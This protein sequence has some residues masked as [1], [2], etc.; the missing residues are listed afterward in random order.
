[1][2]TCRLRQRDHNEQDR[3]ARPSLTVDMSILATSDR[4]RLWTS[5]PTD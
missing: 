3:R 2:I 1:M 4:T 5:C